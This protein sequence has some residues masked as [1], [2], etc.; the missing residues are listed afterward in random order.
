MINKFIF[1]KLDEEALQGISTEVP[2]IKDE[3]NDFTFHDVW[4]LVV[5][6]SAPY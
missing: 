5:K 1:N 4:S 3:F 6:F 2:N